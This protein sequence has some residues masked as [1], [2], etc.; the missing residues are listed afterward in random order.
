MALSNMAMRD[1]TTTDKLIKKLMKI[2]PN[3]LLYKMAQIENYRNQKKY[4]IAIEKTLTL[5]KYNTK[6][7]PLRLSLA[8]TYLK[9]NRFFDSE[10]ILNSLKNSHPNNPEVWFQLAEVRGLSGDIPGVH[11]ARAEYFILIGVFDKARDQLMYA[12]KLLVNDYNKKLLIDQRLKNL[13]K[14]E[15]DMRN[16]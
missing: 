5:L 7:Y 10:K 16:L 1:F 4:S 15:E 8:E 14:I 9:A 13:E 6:S 2:S 3:E 11:R 12:R